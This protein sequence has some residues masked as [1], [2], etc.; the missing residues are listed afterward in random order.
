MTPQPSQHR[1]V[2][3]ILLGGGLAATLDIVYAI[4]RFNPGNPLSIGASQAVGSRL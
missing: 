3:A 1:A 4:L 2:T